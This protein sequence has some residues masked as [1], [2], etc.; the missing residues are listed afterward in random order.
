[1]SNRASIEPTEFVDIK[2]G[3]KTLGVRVYDDYDQAYDNTWEDM[4][5]DDLDILRRVRESHDEKICSILSL[6]EEYEK[7]IYIGRRWYDWDEIKACF[8]E[9]CQ[10]EG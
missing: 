3:E 5:D 9:E 4:P 8:R 10:V 6:I 2:G 7:G 1:M